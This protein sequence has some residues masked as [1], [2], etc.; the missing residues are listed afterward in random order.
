MGGRDRPQ[1]LCDTTLAR[2]PAAI[3]VTREGALQ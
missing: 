3:I 1:H 2:I